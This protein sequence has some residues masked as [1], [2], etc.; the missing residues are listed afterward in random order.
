MG[1]RQQVGPGRRWQ[2]LPAKPLICSLND[3]LYMVIIL[4][5]VQLIE[6]TD[7]EERKE[8]VCGGGW[9]WGRANALVMSTPPPPP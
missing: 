9:P 4:F 5:P 3:I 6:C 8:G 1:V 7:W 2:Q